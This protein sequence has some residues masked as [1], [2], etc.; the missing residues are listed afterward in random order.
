[1]GEGPGGGAEAAGVAIVYNRGGQ[2]A[3]P[4]RRW[5][6]SAKVEDDMLFAVQIVCIISGIVL[7]AAVVMQTTKAD[8]FSAAMGS[9]SADA[10][11][12]RKGSKEDMLE[13][14]TK[15]SAIVWLAFMI[16]A[17]ILWYHG[18]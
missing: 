17:A 4:M 12:F 7:I 18:R 1:V 16:A 8:G 14:V 11:R 15:A 10:S 2:D 5:A 3:R 13:K 6:T 9:G